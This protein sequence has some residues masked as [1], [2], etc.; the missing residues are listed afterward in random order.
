MILLSLFVNLEG[1]M[2]S[3]TP[4]P[5]ITPAV[6]STVPTSFLNSCGG[7]WKTSAESLFLPIRDKNYSL[8][9]KIIS[10]ESKFNGITNMKQNE[11]FIRI[12]SPLENASNSSTV[13]QEVPAEVVAEASHETGIGN[14][15]PTK[16]TVQQFME[17]AIAN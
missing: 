12:E 13:I 7:H 2:A 6:C 4:P 16:K 8:D 11:S 17:R 1:K 10:I 3:R 9:G 15:T 5:I 14:M